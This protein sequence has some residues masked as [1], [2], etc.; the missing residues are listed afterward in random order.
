MKIVLL[1]TSIFIFFLIILS[2]KSEPDFNGTSTGCEAGGCH[3]SEA[4]LI[5]SEI[6]DNF[7]VKVTVNGTISEVG[8]ELVNSSGVVVDV[9]ESTSDNPF[10]LIAPSNGIY[11]VYA[12]FANP[13]KKWDSTTAVI[14]LTGVDE[15][16]I[17]PN[18]KSFELY[19]NYPN[20][21]N[22]ETKIRYAI[23]K[24]TFTTLVVYSL[25]GQEVV[26]LINEEKTPGV[27]E[28]TFDGSKLI[29][30]MYI[31]K[32]QAGDYTKT[33]KMVLIK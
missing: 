18:P 19:S 27:Y 32:L 6:L 2:A 28:V 7:Q 14:N 29:S 23:A 24:T 21:F 30:G 9:I 22:P 25:L 26:I 4:D 5:T 8:G 12:G 20:P 16:F 10:I 3:N 17:A 13:A 1:L 11:T 31:Y 33:K 15:H